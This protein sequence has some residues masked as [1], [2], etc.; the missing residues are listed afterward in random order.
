MPIGVRMETQI[1]WIFYATNENKRKARKVTPEYLN[2]LLETVKKE[3]SE[4]GYEFGRWIGERLAT[5][6]AEQTGLQL[7]SSQIRRIRA[8]KK[9]SLEF[10]QNHK[11][12]AKFLEK[13]TRYL[14]IT[15]EKPEHLQVCFW[16][17]TE[18]SL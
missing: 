8:S 6:L 4:L 1:T 14:A 11:I 3:P 12:R 10:K 2:L 5:Y 18:F 17:E 16:D 15:R 9:Y 7:S 13:L